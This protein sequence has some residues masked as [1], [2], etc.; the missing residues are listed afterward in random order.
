MHMHLCFRS[1]HDYNV[2][3]IDSHKH[4]AVSKLY[5]L[6]NLKPSDHTISCISH[7]NLWF[8]CI[9]LSCDVRYEICEMY[10][11]LCKDIE[12][13]EDKLCIKKNKQNKQKHTRIAT[14]DNT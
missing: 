8:V 2:M 13:K 4:K 7:L 3:L 12:K 11:I 6:N 1:R 5:N 14:H 10:A 9:K